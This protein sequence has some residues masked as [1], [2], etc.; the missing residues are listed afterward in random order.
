MRQLVAML[1]ISGMRQRVLGHRPR[2]PPERGVWP[3]IA[4]LPTEK[5]VCLD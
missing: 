3:A 2:P 1:A 4:E 5:R